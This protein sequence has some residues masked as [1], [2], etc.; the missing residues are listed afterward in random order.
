[1]QRY[2]ITFTEISLG[3]QM[4]NSGKFENLALLLASGSSIKNASQQLGIGAR[5]A[6]RISAS[7]KMKNRVSQLRTEVA[8]STVG[9]LTLAASEAAAALRELLDSS[10][11]PAVR[12]NSAKAV[13]A[14]L[15]AISELGELRARIDALES[16]Q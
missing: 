15:S 4:A 7:D 1:M 5:T 8:S 9:V 11:P 6:Y 16:K 12:L 3:Q 2:Q 14:S 10:N 13:L